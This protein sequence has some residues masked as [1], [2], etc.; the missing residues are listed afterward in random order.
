MPSKKRSITMTETAASA[1]RPE[2]HARPVDS[3]A[4]GVI[5][6][7]LSTWE[8]IYNIG[9]V[10]K[11]AILLALAAIWEIYAR[12]LHNPLLFPTFSVTV[13]AFADAVISGELPGKAWTS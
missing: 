1:I 2:R 4:F 3:A 5:Q 13:Q 6:K 12:L 8:R 11:L 7:P 10:R 9:A